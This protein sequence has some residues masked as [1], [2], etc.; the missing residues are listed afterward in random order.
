MSSDSASTTPTLAYTEQEIEDKKSEFSKTLEHLTTYLLQDD[1]KGLDYTG[2][3]KFVENVHQL[4]TKLEQPT[5]DRVIDLKMYTNELGTASDNGHQT[6]STRDVNTH[7]LS[8][9]TGAGGPEAIDE[10]WAE[11]R[12]RMEMKAEWGF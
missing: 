8:K 9:A 3:K 1:L 4:Y 7:W 11:Y 2:A 6:F 12:A 5:V 10:A